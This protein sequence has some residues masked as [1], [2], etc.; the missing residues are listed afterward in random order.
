MFHNA[1]LSLMSVSRI[2]WKLR[3]NCNQAAHILLCIKRQNGDP[4]IKT[5]PNSDSNGTTGSGKVALILQG[6]AAALTCWSWKKK[7]VESGG[8]AAS[9]TPINIPEQAKSISWQGK[10]STDRKTESCC[11]DHQHTGEVWWQPR[12]LRAAGVT[13]GSTAVSR[14]LHEPSAWS[15]NRVWSCSQI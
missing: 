9:G 4:F 10:Y 3:Q 5:W 14:V 11:S 2:T 1:L 8:V 15:Q 13:F 12:H 7:W 6:N